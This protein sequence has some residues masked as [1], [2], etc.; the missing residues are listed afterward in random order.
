MNIQATVRGL[1]ILSICMLSACAPFGKQSPLEAP[2]AYSLPQGQSAHISRADWWMQLRNPQLNRLIEQAFAGSPD[3]RTAKARF[4][5]AQAQLGITEAATGAQIGASIRGAGVYVSPKPS[6]QQGDPDHTMVLANAA[7]QG[8]WTFDFW[9]KNRA[10]IASVL[11]QRRAIAYETEQ[12]KIELA[13]AVAAQY[14]AWQNLTGQQ[15]LLARRVADAAET[16]KLLN[17]RI[18]A[19]LLPASAAYPAVLAQQQLRAQQL[20]LVRNAARVR[21]SLAV[22]SGQAPNALDGGSPSASNTAPVLVA[23]D[24]RA[25]LLGS[26]PDIAAQRALLA[27]RL[28]NVQAARAEFYPNIELKLLA[29]FAHIDAFNLVHGKNSGM[30][31]VLPALNL[32]IFTSG[33]LQSGLAARHAEYNQQVALYDQTVLNAMRSAADAV[34]DYQTLQGQ[35][36][37]QQRAASVAEKAAAATQRRMRAGLD[38]KLAYLQKHDEALQVQMQLVQTQNEWLTAWSNLH[39]QLG[40]GFQAE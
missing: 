33:A 36:A 2:T 29:G 21:H 35:A 27:S 12:I 40:G 8:S 13:H 11:G 17:Q 16:E 10:K 25:D 37:L 31:G 28:Q 9:G 18:R 23:A 15:Q 38:N 3:L 7:L 22:L 24:I 20:Q 30:L 39:A 1:G 32:P 19:D 34:S 14:F 5:Q 26:R 4:E 6:A